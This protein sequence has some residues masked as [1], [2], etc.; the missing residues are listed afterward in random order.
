[1]A[2]SFIPGSRP[3]P[4]GIR[5]SRPTDELEEALRL[6]KQ[7]CT[8]LSMPLEGEQAHG[9]RIRLVR[10]QALSVVDLLSDITGDRTRMG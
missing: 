9:V 1:M 2:I 3:E 8:R 10:A 6:A 5:P 7:L 4:S